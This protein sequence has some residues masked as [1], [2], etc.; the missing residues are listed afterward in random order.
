MVKCYMTIGSF[1]FCK[2]AD[3]CGEKSAGEWKE[4]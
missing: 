2:Q 1:A 4:L 3:P